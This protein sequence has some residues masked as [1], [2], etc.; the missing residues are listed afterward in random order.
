MVELKVEHASN[1]EGVVKAPPSKSYTHRAL[2]LACLAKGQS[3]LSDPL[4]SADTLSTLKACQ[5]LGCDIEVKDDS[6]TVQGTAGELKTPEDVLDLGN[7]GTTLRFLTTMTS[8]APGCSVLTGDDSLRS[9]PMQ[10]LLDS[11]RKLGVKAYSTRGNGLPPVVVKGGFIGGESD[12]NGGVSSQFISS[13]LLSAPYAQN[14]VDLQVVGAFKSRPY[15]EMTLDIMEKFGTQCRQ[16]PGNKFHLDQQ[17]YQAQDYTI[18]GDYSS[19]SYLLSAAAIV[20]GEVTVLNLFKDSK[21]GDKLILDILEKM[22]ASIKARGNQVTVKGDSQERKTK[23][24]ITSTLTSVDV[25]LENSPDL[26]PTVAALAAVAQ[27]TSHITGVEHARYKET[28]RVHTMALELSKLGVD[29]TEERDSLTIT[30]GAHPGVV[31]SHTDHRL[32]MSLSLVGLLTGGV[33]IKGAEAYQVS[34]PNFPQVMTDLGCSI[35]QN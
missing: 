13:I 3:Q 18:E 25:N 17:T 33:C 29:V 27:G 32:V 21:Q 15:V 22:G 8:L 23:G 2:L 35:N 14:P 12:I 9:R 5:A 1:I 26:L 7:S 31:E 10:D 24:K 19:A 28:D 6:C 30:G 20:G 34:F 11:L 16:E 4:Y